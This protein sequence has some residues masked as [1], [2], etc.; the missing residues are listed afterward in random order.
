ME[1][2]IDRVRVVVRGC[3][4]GGPEVFHF[5]N[6]T[7]ARV[8]RNRGD[9]HVREL[10]GAETQRVHNPVVKDAKSSGEKPDGPFRAYHA[11]TESAVLAQFLAGVGIADEDIASQAFQ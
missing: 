4:G 10:S 11:E 9:K 5:V 7:A 1:R 8:Y 6:Q 3:S 2:E